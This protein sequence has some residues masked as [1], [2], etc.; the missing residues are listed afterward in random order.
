MEDKQYND[1][2]E[3]VFKLTQVE[4]AYFRNWLMNHYPI[5][6]LDFDVYTILSTMDGVEANYED[7]DN[8][9]KDIHDHSKWEID[10]SKI[11]KFLKNIEEEDK[12]E[13]IVYPVQQDE[14]ADEYECPECGG[15]IT[16]V[17]SNCPTCGVELRFKYEKA[18]AMN[19]EQLNDLINRLE[20][21]SRIE[22][23]Y[24]RFW[25]TKYY[26]S[27][28]IS[29]SIVE[30]YFSRK[31]PDIKHF[32]VFLDELVEYEEIDNLLKNVKDH[33]TWEVEESFFS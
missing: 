33:S 29:Q 31:E 1:I 24:V 21:L 23:E 8:L 14:R 5:L 3:R 7:V 6:G 15:K 10:E 2:E 28:L 12:K 18:G 22:F 20:K 19:P 11:L 4:L 9:L 30:D 26:P 17:M 16:T 25:V 27:I 13:T 32:V